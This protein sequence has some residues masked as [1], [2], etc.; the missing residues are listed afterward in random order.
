MAIIMSASETPIMEDHEHWLKRAAEAR[1]IA[2]S[3]DDLV[4]KAQM[5]EVARS[6]EA[7]AKRIRE[8]QTGKNKNTG[9]YPN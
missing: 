4:A 5:L 8:R 1:A 7:V 3:M 2:E 6:Y 9:H